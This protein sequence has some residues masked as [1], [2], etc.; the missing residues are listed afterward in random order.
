MDGAVSQRHDSEKIDGWPNKSNS[1]TVDLLLLTAPRYLQTMLLALA[2]EFIQILVAPIEGLPPC[3]VSPARGSGSTFLA[4]K[5]RLLA[6]LIY[7]YPLAF[8]HRA[9]RPR[10]VP[11]ISTR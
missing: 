8:L 11:T 4:M 10:S 9:H 3:R 5:L 1:P 2:N 7:L 6:L